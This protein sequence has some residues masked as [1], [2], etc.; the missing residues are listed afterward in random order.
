MD[1][2]KYIYI[3]AVYIY[4]YIYIATTAANVNGTA[5]TASTCYQLLLPATITTV[6][7]EEKTQTAWSQ[8]L[9]PSVPVMVVQFY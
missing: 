5:S 6:T 9:A 7:K 4:I 1:I 3:Y 8:V 2:H